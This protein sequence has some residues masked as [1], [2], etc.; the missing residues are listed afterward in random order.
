MALLSANTISQIGNTLTH[1]AV[2]WFVLETTGSAA[3]A[4]LSAVF[5]AL[6]FAVSGIIGGSIVDRLGFKPTSILSDLASGVTVALI[7]LLYHTVGLAYWQL[8]ILIFLG[9][10]LDTP[11]EAARQ[12]LVPDLATT[13]SV[14]LERV[15]GINESL[16]RLTLLVGPVLAGTL[17]AAVGPTSVLMIDAATFAVSAALV[18]VAVPS[19]SRSGSTEQPS[20]MSL[21]DVLAGLRFILQDQLLRSLMMILALAYAVGT[22]LL[23]VVMPV[24]ANQV[25]GSA[26]D[27]GVLLAGFGGGTLASTLIYSA[28]GPRLPR[29]LTFRGSLILAG[30]PFFVLATTPALVGTFITLFVRGVVFGPINPLAMTLYHERIPADLRGRVLGTYLSLTAGTVAIG[31]GITGYTVEVMGL[32]W[33]LL[34]MAIVYFGLSLIPLYSRAFRGLK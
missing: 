23:T 2:L 10:V 21:G 20:A 16:K 19:A 8:L 9:A 14:R 6:P 15:N 24:Y 22:S 30:L 3:Q 27:L 12:S 28:F 5:M 18:S 13:G 32:Q 11:G 31:L 17:I 34:A 29:L 25:F 4:G 7:P 33:A 26:A 1:I